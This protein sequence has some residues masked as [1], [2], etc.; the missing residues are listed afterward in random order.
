MQMSPRTPEAYQ[1]LHDSILTLSQIENDGIRIDMGYCLEQQAHM[2]RTIQRLENNL[3]KDELIKAW[4]DKYGAKC[5]LDSGHQLGD[6]LFNVMGI[7]P[8]KVTASGG[9]ATDKEA[10][11]NIDIPIVKNLLQIRKLKKANDTYL[12]GVMREAVDGYLHPFFSLH[13]VR[14]FR[15]SSQ[16]P[17]F[18][19]IP[20][21]DEEIKKVVRRAFIPREGYVFGGLDFGAMEVKISATYHRDPTMIKYIEDPTTDMHRDVSMDCFML[22]DPKLVHKKVRQTSKGAFTFAQLYGDYYKNC[23]KNLW[24]AVDT[25]GLVVNDTSETPMKLYLVS[26]GIDTYDKFEE[27][28]R[29]VEDKFWN[30]RFPVYTQWKKDWVKQYEKNGFFDMHTG[31]RCSGLMGKNDVLNYQIQGSAFHCLLWSMC[32]IREWLIKYKLKTKI[33][34]QIHDELVLDM[35]E[36]EIELVLSKCQ[37]VMTEDIR[38]AWPWICVPL[39]VD[40]SF[41]PPESSWYS[42]AEM[43][44]PSEPHRVIA[45]MF[46][47]Q[48]K[49]SQYH[50]C[51]KPI[52]PKN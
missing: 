21:R 45:D 7:E 38:K 46:F 28:I 40:A 23:A 36:S 52:K 50:L 6:M 24:N 15:G 34:G 8:T 44:M 1:L 4:R 13:N 11:D 27:H 33:V 47:S 25:E 42:K 20:I 31:F 2:N 22:D 49:K 16:N 19:N 30:V 18:Q 41:C 17:N 32:R 37:E 48:D 43:F 14:S 26:K 9:A 29:V 10:L 12:T 5:N 35:H 51:V 39:E 3:E